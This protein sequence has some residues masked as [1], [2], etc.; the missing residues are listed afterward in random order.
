MEPTKFDPTSHTLTDDL[1][2]KLKALVPEAF[3]EESIDF[4]RLKTLL[5]EM[6]DQGQERYSFTWPG[7]TK[8]I[9]AAQTSSIGTLV[10]DK[11]D[12]EDW[13]TTGNLYL[14]GD[15]LEI[16]KLLQKSYTSKAK[17]IYIDPPYNTGKDFVYPDNYGEGLKTYLEYTRQVDGEGKKITTNTETDG[18]YHS[19]WLNMMYPRLML[20]RNLLKD[21]GVIFISIDDHEQ[22]NLKKICDE[23]FG[24]ENFIAQIIWE[25]AFSP[26][27]DSKFF[28]E[29]HDYIL[30]YSKRIDLFELGSLARTD[31][32]NARYKNYDN[33][34]RGVWISDN[35]TVKT[36]SSKYDYPITTPNGTVITVTKGRC[37]SVSKE[38]FAELVSDNRI[39][40][41]ENGG[42]VPRLKRFLSDVSDG[43]TPITIWK[44][45]DVGHNQ[46][47]RQELKKLFNG[48][49]YF[50]SPKP[51]RLLRQILKLSTND[52]DLIIDFFS[53]SATTAHAVIE[54]NAED[55]G[56]RH[57]IMSQLQEETPEDSEARKDG[58]TNIAKIGRER[59]RRAGAKTKEEHL[60][61][62][63]ERETPLDIG[64]R[65]YRLTASTFN[66]WDTTS[67][68]DL[69][70]KLMNTTSLIK[71]DAKDEDVLAE[72]ILKSG[73]GLTELVQEIEIGS[74]KFYSVA[75]GEL[76]IS[77]G[78][79][80]DESVVRLISDKAPK[81][82][83]ARETGFASD[84]VLTNT[85][86]IMKDKGVDF[87]VL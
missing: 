14:E 62:L 10:P 75:N 49:G 24:A 63:M 81:R 7:K 76:L 72:L 65:T 77:L 5:G 66:T 18:R 78:V 22:S 25:R 84:S 28:S 4:E 80:L 64:F 20:A 69:Q 2:A 19:K 86:Q 34:P 79:G 21:D 27:N 57:F 39:W 30:V 32:A 38:K 26:K 41:G 60:E 43:M 44:H 74:K 83:V 58:Y 47:G 48:D 11:E 23:V 40:F 87:R 67:E 1:K 51:V 53:G 85:A 61:R 82:F 12:S 29:N 71:N 46:E 31:S 59:I 8:A 45:Q 3:T 37:W 33:D 16:L 17:L 36:Y 9:R 13:D 15:N 42:N 55:G 70:A 54:L 73:Y 6:T 52:D 50:D 35:L 56:R 68:D